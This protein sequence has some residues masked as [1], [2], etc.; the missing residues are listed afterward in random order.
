M[1]INQGFANSASVASCHLIPYVRNVWQEKA[2]YPGLASKL[3]KDMSETWTCKS[4]LGH[5][6]SSTIY[7][8]NLD[9]M[10]LN[11]LSYFRQNN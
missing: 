1:D 9:L 8:E 6:L 7:L 4:N 5:A 2:M 10:C 11:L 3:S